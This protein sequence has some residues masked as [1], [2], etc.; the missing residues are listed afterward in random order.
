MSSSFPYL[1]SVLRYE[2]LVTTGDHWAAETDADV[3][4]TLNGSQGDAGRR[5][6]HK[7]LSGNK[8]FQ[9]GAVS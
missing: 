7:S 1:A 6:L 3:W 9:K 5:L 8:P 4:V 2:V